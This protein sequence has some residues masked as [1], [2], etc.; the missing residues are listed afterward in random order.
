MVLVYLVYS[1]RIGNVKRVTYISCFLSV[2]LLSH[3]N[4]S[5]RFGLPWGGR[6]TG[7]Y[8]AAAYTL[9]PICLLNDIEFC[10]Y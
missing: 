9:S 4:C 7:D 1:V 8:Y 3:L 5:F 6:P 10:I 2:K